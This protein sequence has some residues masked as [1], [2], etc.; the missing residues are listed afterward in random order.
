MNVKGDPGKVIRR[1]GFPAARAIVLQLRKAGAVDKNSPCAVLYPLYKISAFL[2][3][4]GRDSE[5]RQTLSSLLQSPYGVS[6]T[7]AAAAAAADREDQLF[8]VP[9][10]GVLK[11]YMPQ[12][13]EFLFKNSALKIEGE[14]IISTTGLETEWQVRLPPTSGPS[15]GR[16]HSVSHLVFPRPLSSRFSS[17]ALPPELSH[18]HGR[19]AV[20]RRL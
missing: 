13:G 11:A 17:T 2:V 3:E 16:R 9:R 10:L 6:Q 1:F 8:P 15:S 4:K 14:H 18:G 12:K 19:A 7:A 5:A 20:L